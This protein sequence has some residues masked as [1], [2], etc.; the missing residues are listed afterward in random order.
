M[1]MRARINQGNRDKYAAAPV[2]SSN[3]LRILVTDVTQVMRTDIS[4]ATVPVPVNPK[5]I[6]YSF[7]VDPCDNES[8]ETKIKEGKYRWHFTT[9]KSEGWKKDG[10]SATVKHANKVLDLF[11]ERSV[12]F[13][14]DNIMNILTS[15]T[16]A[17]HSTPQTIVG[18]DHW[19]AYVRD[20]INILTSYH[21]M[22]LD[23]VRAFSGWFMVDEMSSLTK[24]SDM[25][26]NAIDPNKAGNLGRVNR[27]K[28]HL[29]Q[30]SGALHFI[31]NNHVSITS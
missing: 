18:M 12:Q 20:Y 14:L 22:S 2:I 27:Y 4:K 28:I 8:F 10:I 24:S 1:A 7:V 26:I 17:V 5:T 21:H 3:I 6:T 9:K 15:G 25:N 30:I 31:L 29:K 13:E 23:Q 11:K 16:G 19:N